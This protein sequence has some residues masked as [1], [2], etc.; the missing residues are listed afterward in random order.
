MAGLSAE[1]ATLR[2]EAANGLS[3]KVFGAGKE[4]SVLS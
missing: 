3:G 4:V 1:Q 2:E